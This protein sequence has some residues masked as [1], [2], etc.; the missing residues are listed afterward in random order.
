MSTPRQTVKA[1]I[2]D[3]DRFGLTF[4]LAAIFHGILILGVTFT[5]SPPADSQTP[6]ALDIVLLQTQTA[7]ANDDADYLAQVSQR[8]GGDETDKARRR[9]LFSA[10]TL[11]QQ[12]GMAMPSPPRQSRRSASPQ[13]LSLLR[14]RHADYR[15]RNDESDTREPQ[16]AEQPEQARPQPLQSARLAAE[17]SD[18]I[19]PHA[20]GKR[21]KFLNSSTR[22]F[23]A[24][25][26]M[27]QW[28]DRVERIGNLNYPDQARRQ[29]LS[30]TLILDVAIDASGRLLGTD[31]RQ[32]SGHQLLDDAARRIVQLAAPY[33]PFPPELRRQADVIHITR[34]WEF[35]A[36]NQ[37]HSR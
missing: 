17:I 36:S 21:V 15:L 6:P 18:M 35:L 10:P 9:D 12:P 29:K 37:L 16:Q 25:R 7:E 24:A 27:R 26:Y 8:G 20:S 1:D 30:G 33:K 32:S 5:F 2:S 13:R 3:H 11:A 31:L 22:E 34:S 23:V 14:Q 28:I 4:L 19:D